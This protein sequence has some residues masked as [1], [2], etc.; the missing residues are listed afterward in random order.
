MNLFER[1]FPKAAE[2]DLAIKRIDG[3]V[4]DVGELTIKNSNLWESY[5]NEH[6]RAEGYP[7]RTPRLGPRFASRTTPTFC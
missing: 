3:L 6:T 7:M 2:L 4:S 1:L 5:N